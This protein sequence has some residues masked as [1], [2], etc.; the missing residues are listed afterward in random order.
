MTNG[1]TAK[2]TSL[3]ARYRVPTV[4]PFRIFAEVKRTS[5]KQCR[6]SAFDPKRTSGGALAKCRSCCGSL[7]R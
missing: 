7:K 5:A 4:Y 2:C 1:T 6:M 3:F